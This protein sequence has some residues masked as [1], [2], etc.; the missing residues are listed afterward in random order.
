MAETRHPCLTFI[1][2]ICFV[3][4]ITQPVR[5][6]SRP[7][8]VLGRQQR[9]QEQPAILHGSRNQLTCKQKQECNEKHTLLLGTRHHCHLS[10]PTV[11][12]YSRTT[13]GSQFP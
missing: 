8:L 6:L 7:A 5:V 13:Q 11:R 4:D 2:A 12:E 9:E 10:V 1:F 3:F